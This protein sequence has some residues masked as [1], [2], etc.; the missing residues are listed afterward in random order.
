MS[1]F[2]WLIWRLAAK[3]R[4][5]PLD[6]PP[7]DPLPFSHDEFADLLRSDHPDAMRTLA[8]GLA[9]PRGPET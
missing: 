9:K 7:T 4:S 5:L 6:T 3:G 2:R 1:Y 8:A